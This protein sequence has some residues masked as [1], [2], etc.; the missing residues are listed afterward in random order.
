ML[1]PEQ[2]PDEVVEALLATRN[3]AQPWK[4]AIAAAIN[5]WA[6][7]YP[8]AENDSA[9]IRCAVIILPLLQEPQ[10]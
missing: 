7:S 5:A 9:V 10:P 2:V 8:L 3:V 1:K 4:H 6:R